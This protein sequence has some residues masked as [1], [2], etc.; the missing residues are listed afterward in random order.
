MDRHNM[1]LFLQNDTAKEHPAGF[2]AFCRNF[3]DHEEDP[4]LDTEEISDGLDSPKE[5]A[6]DKSELYRSAGEERSPSGLE[7]SGEEGSESESDGMSL[8]SQNIPQPGLAPDIEDLVK[9]K[10]C[11]K[12]IDGVRKN[13]GEGSSPESSD[14]GENDTS[15]VVTIDSQGD[16]NEEHAENANQSKDDK[17]KWFCAR[18]G[19]KKKPR[20]DSLFCSDSCGVSAIERDILFS[21]DYATE[22]HPS[23]LRP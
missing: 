10:A 17:T 13:R 11:S 2:E 8:D 23:L 5:S 6:Q 16:E 7:S 9:K 18:P 14:T 22:I 19:C 15:S 20:F 21:F 1:M 4:D 12:I 3:F